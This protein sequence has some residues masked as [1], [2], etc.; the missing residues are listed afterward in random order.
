MKGFKDYKIRKLEL[1]DLHHEYTKIPNFL[2]FNNHITHLQKA[3]LLVILTQNDLTQLS[4]NFIAKSIGAKWQTVQSN[5]NALFE[6]GYIKVIGYEL[7]VDIE[8]FDKT[9]NVRSL[10]NQSIDNRLVGNQPKGSHPEDNQSEDN[11]SKDNIPP[12]NKEVEVKDLIKE[13]IKAHYNPKSN[14]RFL[15]KS[16]FYYD[17]IA[18]NNIVPDHLRTRKFL[19]KTIKETY[20]NCRFY[21]QP[22]KSPLSKEERDI[23][24]NSINEEIRIASKTRE[25]RFNKTKFLKDHKRHTSIDK[26]K[27]LQV[28]EENF[29]SSLLIENDHIRILKS[30][31]KDNE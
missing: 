18:R 2:I 20:P 19:T 21:W 29:K 4:L 14:E 23:L 25:T 8:K 30:T 1:D 7:Y 27:I 31:Q 6:S 26:D 13:S 15:V 10:D 12:I 28:L 22:D 17:F 24:I 9:V 16:D 5:V 3:I 11:Q